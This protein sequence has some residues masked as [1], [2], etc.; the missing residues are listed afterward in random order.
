MND[1][2]EL[3]PIRP[4]Y[5][6]QK[7]EGFIALPHNEVVLEDEIAVGDLVGIFTLPNGQYLLSKDPE[8]T[9][10]EK[11]TSAYIF[12]NSNITIEEK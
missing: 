2:D 6:F 7:I 5:S 4:T 3:F 9:L 11:I 1:V 8:G 10:I 12:F